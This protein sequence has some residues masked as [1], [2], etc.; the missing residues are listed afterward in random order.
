MAWHSPDRVVETRPL[1]PWLKQTLVDKHIHT[2][3]VMMAVL[4]KKSSRRIHGVFVCP[5]REEEVR[6]S[7][8][9]QSQCKSIA[10]A[11]SRILSSPWQAQQEK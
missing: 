8:L 10:N 1:I 2:V 3:S 4:S 9:P 5:I 7:F 6:V 11:W